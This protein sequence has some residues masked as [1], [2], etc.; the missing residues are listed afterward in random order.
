S[1]MHGRQF[2]LESL[3]FTN[4]FLNLETQFRLHLYRDMLTSRFML[5][6]RRSFQVLDFL[7]QIFP[8]LSPPFTGGDKFLLVLIELL[9]ELVELGC[10]SFLDFLKELLRRGVGPCDC[11]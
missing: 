4:E 1:L 11:V 10:V 8:L 3:A 7:I 2:S 5:A 6:C 9:L